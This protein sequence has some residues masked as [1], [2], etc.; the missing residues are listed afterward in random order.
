MFND[1]FALV[2]SVDGKKCLHY[3]SNNNLLRPHKINEPCKL[4]SSDDYNTVLLLENGNMQI[5]KNKSHKVLFKIEVR[6][7]CLKNIKCFTKKIK[8]ENPNRIIYG[9]KII[10]ICGIDIF[11][12]AHCWIFKKDSFIYKKIN[13]LPY[14]TAI[15]DSSEFDIKI[16][17]NGIIY[18]YNIDI[19]NFYIYNI[20]YPCNIL[21]YIE[22][23]HTNSF[24]DSFSYCY[25][26]CDD[27]KLYKYNKKDHSLSLIPNISRLSS[28]SKRN[29]FGINTDGIMVSLELDSEGKPRGKIQIPGEHIDDFYY[30]YYIGRSY[31]ST[32]EGNFYYYIGRMCPVI[33]YN[34][35]DELVNV[36]LC[37][38][39]KQ[40][41]K[42][43]RKCV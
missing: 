1:K 8:Y 23:N 17:S 6:N 39:F 20:H 33:R 12:C 13:N 15:Y 22:E 38:M 3:M 19:Y 4:L 16:I 40:N 28:S 27:L 25:L 18:I 42:S 14:V 41:V 21:E 2:P 37:P 43:S 10:K 34:S 7:I 32:L 9:K 5:F 11:G 35:N 31:I 36:K 26:F 24:G 30:D 29:G